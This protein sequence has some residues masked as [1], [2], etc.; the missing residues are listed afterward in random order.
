[1]TDENVI[2]IRV[3]K[4]ILSGIPKGDR[5]LGRSGSTGPKDRPEA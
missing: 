2:E 1:M 5:E 3:R 4:D